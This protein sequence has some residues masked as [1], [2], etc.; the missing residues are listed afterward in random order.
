L[1]SPLEKRTVW[2]D[3]QMAQ[4]IYKNRIAGITDNCL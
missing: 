1:R 3:L 4:A 2:D